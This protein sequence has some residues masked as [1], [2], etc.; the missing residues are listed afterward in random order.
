MFV[1]SRNKYYVDFKSNI[2]TLPLNIVCRFSYEV[3]KLFAIRTTPTPNSN[4]KTYFPSKTNTEFH[5]P[6]CGCL[7]TY[8]GSNYNS[9]TQTRIPTYMKTLKASTQRVG[10]FTIYKFTNTHYSHP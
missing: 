9:E 5:V 10:I 8:I 4:D 7:F 2:L 1:F 6:S 3:H